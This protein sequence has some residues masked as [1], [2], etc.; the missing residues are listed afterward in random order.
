MKLYSIC[1]ENLA[2][3]Q[4][5]DYSVENRNLQ[6]V[7]F[8]DLGHIIDFVI[9]NLSPTCQQILFALIQSKKVFVKYL[10]ML[11]SSKKLRVS[12]FPY[13]QSSKTAEFSR[14]MHA[15]PIG[16]SK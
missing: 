8:V 4:T 12:D 7:R 9:R 5:H 16:I 6:A 15:L 2:D 11:Q 13:A 10:A 3:C 14:S 1:Q